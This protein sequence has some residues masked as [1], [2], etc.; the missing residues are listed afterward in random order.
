MW[1]VSQGYK[2]GGHRLE[3]EQ[4]GTRFT[5]VTPPMIPS[6][7]YPPRAAGPPQSAMSPHEPEKRPRLGLFA[8]TVS[9]HWLRPAG[10]AIGDRARD[11]AASIAHVGDCCATS[12]CSSRSILCG[13]P[14]NGGG[15]ILNLAGG[16]D[17]ATRETLNCCSR[18]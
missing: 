4:A 14:L 18:A 8:N 16:P 3:P 2:P 7:Q 17:P 13:Q 5:Q 11:C 15:P 6:I 12:R 9:L 10:G 1:I